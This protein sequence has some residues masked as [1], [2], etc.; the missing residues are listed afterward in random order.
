MYFRVLF[1]SAVQYKLKI[2]LIFCNA[3][4]HF[5]IWSSIL[6]NKKIICGIGVIFDFTK[7]YFEI[8]FFFFKGDFIL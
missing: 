4:Q 5:V 3:G 8:Y 2:N 1:K 7:Y 6:K